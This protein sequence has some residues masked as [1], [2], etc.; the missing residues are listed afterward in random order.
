MLA[1]LSIS[2]GSPLSI[3]AGLKP[4]QD[5]LGSDRS[6]IALAGSL[7]W[8]GTGLGGIPMGWLA[9][10]IGVRVVVLSGPGR[11][12]RSGWSG[13]GRQVPAVRISV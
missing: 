3:V 1:I 5:A 2:Y 10:R 9:D 6:T 4:L 8:V 13:V 7:V 11:Q 12:V